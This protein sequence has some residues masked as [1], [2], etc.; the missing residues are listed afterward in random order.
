MVAKLLVFQIH[1][2]TI[3]GKLW[4]FP[5]K[6]NKNEAEHDMEIHTLLNKKSKT[7]KRLKNSS[8]L[9]I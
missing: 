9:C 3:Q 8:Y 4:A 2:T 1:A 7:P 5:S 6:K